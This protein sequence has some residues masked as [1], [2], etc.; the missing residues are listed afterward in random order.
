MTMLYIDHRESTLCFNAHKLNAYLQLFIIN[1]KVQDQITTEKFQ[2]RLI[3]F[4]W[5]LNGF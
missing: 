3:Y 5:E 2:A 1:V 4:N